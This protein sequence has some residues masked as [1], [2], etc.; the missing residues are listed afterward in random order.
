MIP[1]RICFDIM[2][3]MMMTSSRSLQRNLP[4]T[5]PNDDILNRLLENVQ[6]SERSK[7]PQREFSKGLKSLQSKWK[8]QRR[9][10]PNVESR[11][12]LREE[13]DERSEEIVD[14]EK[15]QGDEG[16]F[17]RRSLGEVDCCHDLQEDWKRVVR[18]YI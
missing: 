5:K 16:G 4:S 10:P 12:G 1:L 8:P 2:M 14:G 13:L 15:G 17:A 9:R 18:V 7:H 3:V 11:H 6:S